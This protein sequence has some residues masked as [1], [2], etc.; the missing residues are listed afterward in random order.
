M[1]TACDTTSV[2]PAKA[3]NVFAT[4]PEEFRRIYG[5]D[6][7]GDCVHLYNERNDRFTIRIE[8]LDLGQGEAVRAVVK[9]L[10]TAGFAT[11]RD[12]AGHSLICIVQLNCCGR[13]IEGL[14][15]SRHDG[16]IL[17]AYHG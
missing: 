2:S 7:F 16:D 11:A 4:R 15:M 14:S 1:E 17:V 3:A 10:S 9:I 13:R 5:V 8:D 12:A 6:I